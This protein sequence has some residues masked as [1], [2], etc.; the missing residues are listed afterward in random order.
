MTLWTVACQVA[1]SMGFSRQ[2]YR[3]G[4]PFPTPGNILEPG[5]EAV[6]LTSIVLA[7]GF[8]TTESPG[9]S[10]IPDPS[11][12]LTCLIFGCATSSRLACASSSCYAQVPHCGGFAGCTVWALGIWASAVMAHRFSC[13]TAWGIFLEQGL[14]P[15]TP[16][17]AS[18][19]LTTVPPG[20]PCL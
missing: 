2:E 16:A 18:G 14:E 7:D 6:S 17:L 3:S 13:C 15:I 8:F 20:K 12:L 1:L 5:I 10:L 11:F 9:K 4:L 19:L